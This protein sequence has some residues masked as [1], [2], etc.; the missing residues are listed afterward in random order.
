MMAGERSASCPCTRAI[1]M[2]I[3]SGAGSNAV[4]ARRPG[5]VI[6]EWFESLIKMDKA[7]VT[8][9]GGPLC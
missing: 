2:V 8:R 5:I 6:V 3:W 4:L 1:M 7:H 9:A